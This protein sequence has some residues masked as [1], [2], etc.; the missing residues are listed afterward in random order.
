LEKGGGSPRPA[1]LPQG[2]RAGRKGEAE[3]SHLAAIAGKITEANAE[4]IFARIARQSKRE[5]EAFLSTVTPDGRVLDR[6]EEVQITV[7]LTVSELKVLERAREVLAARGTVPT[8]KQIMVKALGELV[9]RRDPMVKAQRAAKRRASAAALGQSAASEATDLRT[10]LGQPIFALPQ[11]SAETEIPRPHGFPWTHRKVR[12]T[13]DCIRLSTIK[14]RQDRNLDQATRSNE[15]DQCS[16]V[17][18]TV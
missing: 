17:S 4:L 1:L 8:T 10:A 7:R 6:E 14:W 5:V 12:R 16:F 2:R 9:N 18:T 3:V 15:T 11:G 13:H